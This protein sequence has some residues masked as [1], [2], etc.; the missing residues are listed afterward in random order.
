MNSN[1]KYKTLCFSVIVYPEKIQTNFQKKKKIK[2]NF[3][4][5]QKLV[6]K[7]NVNKI[8]ISTKKIEQT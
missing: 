4:L 7:V 5:V 3:Y 8:N 1:F 2:K 6:H